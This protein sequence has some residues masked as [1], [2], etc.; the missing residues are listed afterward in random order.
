MGT[1][2]IPR[3]DAEFLTWSQNFAMVL[4]TNYAALGLTQPQSTAITTA[5]ITFMGSLTAHNTAVQNAAAAKQTKCANRETFEE[6]IRAL[7]RQIQANPSV[8]D[9]QRA[10]LGITVR[11]EGA[12]MRTATMA[13]IGRPVATI[14]TSARLRHV[15]RF[16]DEATPTSRAKPHGAMGCEIWVKV[17][18]A[19]EA[20]PSDPSQLTF[21]GLDTASPYVAEYDGDDAGKTAHYMLR[22]AMSS[23]EMGPWSETA[24]ATIVG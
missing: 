1:D 21:L 17:A 11:D 4:G 15:L 20:P 3:P 5:Q 19:G 18:P 16:V 12:G 8:T 10:A 24:S 13:N 2:Y 6:A 9:A 7:V 22:W 23:N 14:D